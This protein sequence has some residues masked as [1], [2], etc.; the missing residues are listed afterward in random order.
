MHIV[1]AVVPPLV[2]NL[3]YTFAPLKCR[4][5]TVARGFA[6]LQVGPGAS[7]LPNADFVPYRC[8]R[9]RKAPGGPGEVHLRRACRAR[10]ASPAARSPFR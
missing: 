8:M 1:L 4:I 2:A 6:T 3:R 10:D 7:S 9:L 5:P